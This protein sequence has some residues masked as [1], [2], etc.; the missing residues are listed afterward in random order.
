M[1]F[2]LN[3]SKRTGERKIASRLELGGKK[4]KF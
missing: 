1:K 3:V 4:N 2:G